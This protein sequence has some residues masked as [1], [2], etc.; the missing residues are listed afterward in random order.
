MSYFC[1]NPTHFPIRIASFPKNIGF[2]RNLRVLDLSK[3]RLVNLDGIQNCVHLSELYLGNNSLND[4]QLRHLVSLSE[5]EVLDLS[6]N[7]LRDSKSWTLIE[8][9]LKL[10][11]LFNNMNEYSTIT[12][13]KPSLML[14]HIQINDNNLTNIEF[15]SPKISVISLSLKNN[16]LSQIKGLAN[17]QS[18]QNLHCD[19]NQLVSIESLQ[20]MIN[21]KQITANTNRLTVFNPPQSNTL[22]VIELSSNQLSNFDFLAICPYIK[23]LKISNNKIRHFPDC[24][25]YFINLVS[26][27]LS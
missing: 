24:P 3:N 19:N 21:V 15:S 18:L 26:L 5:L 12:F 14:E 4:S 7:N 17:L 13:K 11:I 16:Q 22:E 2:V 10:R 1:S 8:S 25:S 20:Q 27:D 9:L 23:E 6:H